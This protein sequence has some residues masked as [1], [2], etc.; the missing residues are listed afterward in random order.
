MLHHPKHSQYWPA[1]LRPHI[2]PCWMPNKR[3]FDQIQFSSCAH[4]FS[5]C[6]HRYTASL[7]V[8]LQSACSFFQVFHAVPSHE[9]RGLHPTSNKHTQH[10]TRLDLAVSIAALFVQKSVST[11]TLAS[12]SQLTIRNDTK[13]GRP[14]QGC[15][16]TARAACRLVHRKCTSSAAHAELNGSSSFVHIS[17]NQKG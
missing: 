7:E 2:G 1:H 9:Y 5:S 17:C 10:T 13:T 4:R 14:L 15:R 6:L 16:S 12:S 11:S 8:T 3:L